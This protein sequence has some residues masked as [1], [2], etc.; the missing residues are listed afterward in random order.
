MQKRQ[1]KTAKPGRASES[2]RPASPHV[3]NDEPIVMS[4]EEAFARASV[5][6]P[7]NFPK[8]DDEID[9][10]DIPEQD[11]SGPDVVRG[12]YRELATAAEGFVQPGSDVYSPNVVDD[13]ARQRE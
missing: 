9:L 10:T 2:S 7:R 5:T 3:A 8:N 11:F 6:W 12:K 13:P 1:T 4:A